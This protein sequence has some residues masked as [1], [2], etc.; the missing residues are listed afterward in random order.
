MTNYDIKR[1]ALVLAIQAEVEGMLVANK[2]ASTCS[3]EY[4]G[5][6]AFFEKAEELR[7]VAFKH[8]EQL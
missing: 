1:M 4:F 5:K 8:D 2:K 3:T 6:D 7:N